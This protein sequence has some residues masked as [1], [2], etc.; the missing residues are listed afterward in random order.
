[1]RMGI[2]GVANMSIKVFYYKH[3]YMTIYHI[4]AFLFPI[5][6]PLGFKTTDNAFEIPRRPFP[7]AWTVIAIREFQLWNLR[8]ELRK[9]RHA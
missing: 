8:K 9:S 4:Y 2:G 3:L 5:C 6:V 7:W 1:M